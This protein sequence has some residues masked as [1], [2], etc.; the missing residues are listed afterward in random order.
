L[1]SF[2]PKNTLFFDIETGGIESKESSVFS[3][4]YGQ[5]GRRLR[6]SYASPAKGSFVSRWAEDIVLS[7]IQGKK[8]VSEQRLLEAFLKKLEKRRAGSTLAGWN[9]GYKAIPQASW[10]AG[11]DIPFLVSRAGKY[12]LQGRY[13]QAFGR[14]TTRDIG[15]EFLASTASRI[16]GFAKNLP[17]ERL[18]QIFDPD[19]YRQLEPYGREAFA[20]RQRGLGVPEIARKLQGY[21]VAGWK[22]DLAY[23]L[24]T[25]KPLTSAHMSEADVQAM[26][27]MSGKTLNISDEQFARKW[28]SLALKGRLVSSAKAQVRRG[29]EIGWEALEARATRYGLDWSSIRS[30]IESERKYFSGSGRIWER[31]VAEE[32]VVRARSIFAGRK[33][34]LIGG[35]VA[36]GAALLYAVKPLRWLNDRDEQLEA[37]KRGE[38][39]EVKIYGADDAY[40]EIKGMPEQGIGPVL[41][42]AMTPFGSGYQGEREKD[43]FDYSSSIIPGLLSAGVGGFLAFGRREGTWLNVPVDPAEYAESFTKFKYRPGDIIVSRNVLYD[44]PFHVAIVGPDKSVYQ[45][46]PGAGGKAVVQRESISSYV[47]GQIKI[48]AAEKM[49]YPLF[50][51]V[52][53]SALSESKRLEV[54]RNA[55]GIYGDFIWGTIRPRYGLLA[56][57]G[58]N[59]FNCLSYVSEAYS[60]AGAEF[61]KPEVKRAFPWNVSEKGWEWMLKS[62]RKIGEKRL[63]PKYA[64]GLGLVSAGIGAATGDPL[65]AG[66]GVG[67]VGLSLGSKAFLES[68]LAK[69]LGLV[70]LVLPGK[71]RA[72]FMKSLAFA[73]YT[74][75]A[76][77]AVLRGASDLSDFDAS[78]LLNVAAAGSSLYF[79]KTVYDTIFKNVPKY[80]PKS[81]RLLILADVAA[82]GAMGHTMPAEAIRDWVQKHGWDADVVGG[83]ENLSGLKHSGVGYRAFVDAGYNTQWISGL[84]GVAVQWDV[85]GKNLSSQAK[86]RSIL[87]KNF[88]LSSEGMAFVVPSVEQAADYASVTGQKNFY[89]FNTL[90]IKPKTFEKIQAIKRT[91]AAGQLKLPGI[92]SGERFVTISGGGKGFGVA[93]AARVLQESGWLKETNRKA[94]IFAANLN[95]QRPKA[96]RSLMELVEKDPSRFIVH[97]FAPGGA[98]RRLT[99]YMA[100]ADINLL[101]GGASTTVEATVAEKPFLAFRGAGVPKW[102][103]FIGNPEYAREKWGASVRLYELPGLGEEAAE[104]VTELRGALTFLEKQGAVKSAVP[105]MSEFDA[106]KRIIDIIEEAEKAGQLRPAKFR[107]TLQGMVYPLWKNPGVRRAGLATLGI[108][109]LL[110]VS[111]LISDDEEEVSDR[112]AKGNYQDHNTIPGMPEEGMNAQMRHEMT[113]F[114]SGWLGK[115]FRR[116]GRKA[117]PEAASTGWRLSAQQMREM[118]AVEFKRFVSS[119]AKSSK[120]LQIIGAMSKE[121][122]GNWALNARQ[123]QSLST[124]ELIREIKS[125]GGEAIGLLKGAFKEAGTQVGRIRANKALNPI[126]GLG[127]SGKGI[128]T[129]FGSPWK[130]PVVSGPLAKKVALNDPRMFNTVEG[131][132]HGGMNERKRHEMTPFGGPFNWAKGLFR[133]TFPGQKN[134]SKILS[135]MSKKEGVI[136]FPE[137]LMGYLPK[138]MRKEYSGLVGGYLPLAGTQATRAR[139]EMAFEDIFKVLRAQTRGDEAGRELAKEFYSEAAKKTGPGGGILVSER[140]FKRMARKA[141]GTDVISETIAHE[142]THMGLRVKGLLEDVEEIFD[143]AG[144][145]GGYK[146]WLNKYKKHAYYSKEPGRLAEEYVAHAAG[147]AKRGMTKAEKEMYAPAIAYLKGT[148]ELSE[149]AGLQFHNRMGDMTRAAQQQA[150]L[151]AKNGA[152]NH[153]KHTSSLTNAERGYN[154]A[155]RIWE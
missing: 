48:H 43:A 137:R 91:L 47:R 121:S 75:M 8:T 7:K 84:P 90:V 112:L 73:G 88:G 89:S 98:G 54:A 111:G 50:G 154:N 15:Q 131:L 62:P 3:L 27:E 63:L 78:S 117:L 127:C 35:A 60:R 139:G 146:K 2:L 134:A 106:G 66:Y 110:G 102:E 20:L 37:V 136:V 19:I 51:V 79:G 40:N 72:L 92:S 128:F 123:L 119:R 55:A 10:I 150:A 65:L 152:K 16:Y 97:D 149:F 141:G 108:F 129:D 113:E 53:P 80:D 45:A 103:H 41:R 74:A 138:E 118:S 12:G 120:S 153:I 126:E 71:T 59:E 114:G 96:Y 95:T 155:G 144:A 130:G 34:L 9:I 39:A 107:P 61:F 104:K 151:N 85:Q 87:T 77:P 76:L 115:L 6:T 142:R 31:E 58:V 83:F 29:K 44:A 105:R 24:M 5:R 82:G 147:A 124:E 140:G 23:E 21:R 68:S 1:F 81:K 100:A 22:Q 109:A 4:T 132:V 86:F 148:P 13:Q 64:A 67:M 49:E 125:Q 101:A 14:L 33:G 70:G 30:T 52:R 17:Q 36:A 143:M 32:A 56:N 135:E 145:S 11:F 26:I 93:E 122:G 116:F 133:K 25:G 38:L 69:R 57:Q 42:H 46:W 18:F 99:E 94:V 28:H